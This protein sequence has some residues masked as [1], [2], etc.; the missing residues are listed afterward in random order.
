MAPKKKDRHG[1]WADGRLGHQ[2]SE[3]GAKGAIS[4]HFFVCEMAFMGLKESTWENQRF[5][6][7]K[8]KKQ[9]TRALCWRYPF[10][11]SLDQ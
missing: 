5:V 9:D 4:A 1:A 2:P 10:R 3:R 7:Q 8:K 6:R 11:S